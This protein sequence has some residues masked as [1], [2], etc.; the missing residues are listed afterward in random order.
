MQKRSSVEIG[1]RL[2]KFFLKRHTLN[3]KWG[4]E[5]AELR[6]DHHESAEVLGVLVDEY[7]FIR[8]IIGLP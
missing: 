6:S 5:I 7:E 8:E 3:N 2:L 1:L 4:K